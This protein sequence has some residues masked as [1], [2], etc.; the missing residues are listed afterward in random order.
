MR[1]LISVSSA[2]SLCASGALADATTHVF[3]WSDYMDPVTLEA[4]GE[5][6]GDALIYD[7]YNDWNI[8]EARLVAGGSGYDVAVV[9]SDALGRLVKSGAL[10]RLDRSRLAAQPTLDAKTLALVDGLQ[11]DSYGAV[12]YLSGFTGIA[13]SRA[14]VAERMPDA[15]L[16]SWSMIF[17]P[18]IVSQFSDCG[19]VIVD[20]PEEVVPAALL[21]LGRDPRST[22][23]ED[24]EAAL[25]VVRAIAPHV[26]AFSVETSDIFQDES[27]CL[28]L[29]WST[30][31]V[32]D[33]IPVEQWTHGFALPEEGA[34]AWFDLFV[35]PS[36]APN[37]D[38]AYR[39]IDH[40]LSPEMM[41]LN[42]EWNHAA[43]PVAHIADYLRED[44]R[45]NPMISP[46]EELMSRAV[47]LPPRDP[48]QREALLKL[49]TRA[50]IGF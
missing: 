33:E 9:A 49:W 25:E 50:K 35:I 46:S 10:A 45:D 20:A 22:D 29:T 14:A 26:T 28:A 5:S 17:D 3:N 40:M 11:G 21:W 48:A 47:T 24:I 38:G 19:V 34:I 7:T 31:I 8:A 44:L 30:E 1:I 43:G 37:P 23:P 27:F 32:N 16:N 12:P 2:V 36:D 4:Y 41:A 6:T 18:E 39:F 42:M 13:Y 15:P